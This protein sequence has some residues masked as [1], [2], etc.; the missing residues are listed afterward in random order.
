MGWGT[1]E[2][3]AKSVQDIGGDSYGD[4]WL[5]RLG[6]AIESEAAG[7]VRYLRLLE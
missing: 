4:G 1:G 3:K 6:G 2:T 7:L 5:G